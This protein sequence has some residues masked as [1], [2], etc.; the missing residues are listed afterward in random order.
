MATQQIVILSFLGPR[1]TKLHEN[2]K[3]AV[4]LSGAGRGLMRPAQSKDLL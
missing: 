3:N 1:S 2:N 4:I